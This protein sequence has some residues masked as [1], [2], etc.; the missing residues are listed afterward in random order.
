MAS[1]LL[2]AQQFL[3]AVTTSGI[4][5]QYSGCINSTGSNSTLSSDATQ[6]PGIPTDISSLI[7]FLVSFSALRDWLKLIVFGSA[8]ESCRRLCLYLYTKLYNSFFITA[9]FEEDDSSYD[10]MMVWLSKQPSWKTARDVQ[11]STRTFNL[12]SNA[13]MIE[14]EDED[15]NSIA[16]GNRPLAYLPSE[17]TVHSFWYKRRWVRVTRVIRQGYYNRREEVIELCIMSTTHKV[18][19]ELLIEAKKTY[20]EAQQ[21]TIS[22]Y[23]SDCNNNWNHIASRPKRPLTSIVLDPGVKDLLIDDARDFMASKSWYSARGIPFRRGY[24]LYG[25]PGSGK[26]SIIHSLAG[27]LGLDV[28]I[29]SLSRSLLDDTALS[30]LIS[31]LPEKCIALMEDIDAA[32]NQTLHRDL[33]PEDDKENPEEDDEK[34][35]QASTPFAPTTSRV[36]LSGLLNALDGVGAQEGRILFATTNKYS[37]LDPALCRPGRMDIHIHFKLASK[38]QARELYRCFYLPDSEKEE[39]E[40]NEKKAI[41][42]KAKPADDSGYT[43]VDEKTTLLSSSSSSDAGSTVSSDPEPVI[44]NGSSHRARGP[45]L[46][47]AEVAALAMQFAEII[48]ER[49]FSMAALQGYL[50]AYK[51]RPFEAIKDA[52]AWIEKER[53]EAAKK[54]AKASKKT[55]PSDNV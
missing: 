42:I 3:S 51:V 14:G 46:S 16:H 2:L 31:N 38:F 10:W 55:T 9:R 37:A 34:K 12:S 54:A 44:F 21:N 50:M 39:R 36:T 4:S 47:A 30:D 27:E 33:D 32:F 45:Q 18:L 8:L 28:Y 11:I 49:E 29:I 41:D 1:P 5:D 26:T 6:T 22:I 15:P 17:S 48:P 52:P 23:S 53:H 25:A 35:S 20:Q 40:E 24:L 19:N 7:G 13:V 43:S